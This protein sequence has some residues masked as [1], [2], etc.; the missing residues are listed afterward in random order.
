MTMR[1]KRSFGG[2]A[3]LLALVT[4]CKQPLFMTKADYD[5]YHALG[6]PSPNFETDPNVGAHP[7]ITPCAKPSDINN[8]ERPIRYMSLAECIAIALESG[9]VGNPASILPSVVPLAG[10]VS[11]VP[12]TSNDLLGSFASGTGGRFVGSDAIRV[13]AL[14][15]AIIGAQIELSLSKFDA[16]FGSSMSWT[17]TDRPVGTPLDQFQTGNSGASAIV[18]QQAVGQVGIYKPLATGGVAGITFETDY[19]LTNL[20]ARVN[21]SYQPSL[22]FAFE[23]PLLQGFG[24][25]INQISPN[26]PGSVLIPNLNRVNNF[27]NPGVEG[28]LITRIRFD[29]ERAEFERNVQI[30]VSNVEVA[31]WNLYYAYW[32]LYAQEQ[33]LR[34]SFEAWKI[35]TARFQAGRISV[36]DLAQTRGQYEQF[37]SQR[38]VALNDL[39]DYERAL[40]A[41]LGLQP[42]D[43]YR[44]VPSDKPTLAQYIPDWEVAA[45]ETLTLKPELYLARQEVKANQLKLLADKNALLP[46]L[47]AG[48]TYDANAIGTRLDGADPDNALRQLSSNH[49]NNFGANLR[50]I[51][52][53]G[54]RG[55]NSRLREDQ[56]AL[57]RSYGVLQDQE[58]KALRL[59]AQQYRRVIT[60]YEI[61]RARRS[62][63][64]AFAQQ[65]NVRFQEYIAGREKATLDILLEAQRAWAQALT[66]EYQAITLYSEALVGFE[67]AKG[68]SLQRN[69]IVI[70]EG[71]LPGCIQKR[72]VEHLKERSDS[73]A[74]RHRPEPAPLPSGITGQPMTATTPTDPTSVPE[75]WKTN[76][77]LKDAPHLPEVKD[78]PAAH[79]APQ[80][81]VPAGLPMPAGKPPTLPPP[82]PANDRAPASS[83]PPPPLATPL[84]DPPSEFGKGRDVPGARDGVPVM[85]KDAGND[86]GSLRDPR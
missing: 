11:A 82:A 75:L 32:N 86:F 10:G 24:T 84:S 72:A 29:Q 74:L 43:G 52:P 81:P 47:R 67:F 36:A 83:L 46:D 73:L 28:I 49:F 77:P 31:Y 39:L 37:R 44:L 21:P 63:R 45:Q 42:E 35:N 9:T 5:H 69:N 27:A 71:P 2:L 61:I 68:T 76:P 50:L 22:Q 23:Q 59:L 60:S 26:H 6:L 8:P 40:R 13:L 17:S 38:L 3:L 64:E 34:Q 16:V 19:T 56:L 33:G 7:T 62:A 4:G 12:Q 51:V 15:P 55:A 1:W 41:M 66:D 79:A 30:M 53:I 20:P 70:S 54:F 57:A 18:Q 14:D 85:R 58:L 80:A 65:L 78:Q 25:E 48:L